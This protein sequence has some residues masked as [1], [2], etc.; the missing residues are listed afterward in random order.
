MHSRNNRYHHG[1]R[2]EDDHTRKEIVF[3]CILNLSLGRV[4]ENETLYRNID[5]DEESFRCPVGYIPVFAEEALASLNETTLR[6]AEAVC[7]NDVTCLFDI[8]ATG[9]LAIGQSTLSENAELTNEVND[10]G[11]ILLL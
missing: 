1:P 6:A 2:D 11:K 7:G 4:Q 5:D 9:N 3:L 10:L 8:A